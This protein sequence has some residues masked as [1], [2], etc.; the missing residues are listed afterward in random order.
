MKFNCLKEILLENLSTVLKAVS[1]KATVPQL[2]GVYIHA[3]QNG[4]LT[5]IGNNTEISIKARFEA[6]VEETGIGVLN[7][8]TLFDMVRLMPEGIVSIE[9]KN[10][11][12]TVIQSG[13]TK[14]EIIAMDPEPFPVVEDLMSNFSIKIPENKLKELI[15]KTLFSI[16]TTDTK[17]TFTGALFE[18]DDNHLTVVTLDG[19]RM[20]VRKEEIY[21][22]GEKRSFIIPGRSLNELL[23]ILTDSQNEMTIEFEQKKALMKIENYEFY[24]RL[25]DGEFFNYEQIIPKNA[26]IKVKVKTRDLVEA[27]E[28]A[29]LLITADNKSPIRMNLEGDKMHLNTISRIGHAQDC[30]AIEKEGSDLEIGF[31]HKFVLD[32]LKA[33]ETDEIMMDFSNNLS[34][35]ILRGTDRDDFIYMV[36]PVRLKD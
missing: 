10:N 28:R 31:N 26:E 21:P 27:L 34:P 14:Y 17:I 8:K 7:A 32:A 1:P 23:K 5:L 15:K 29:S 19:Y 25:I 22:T 35:C 2:E 24:T 4:I 33:S 18:V 36:L 11:L 20:A 13:V 16:G 30:V 9:I 6:D 12:T 3:A